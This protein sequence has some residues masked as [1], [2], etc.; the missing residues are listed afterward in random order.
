MLEVLKR[1]SSSFEKES[2]NEE[3]VIFTL[4]S[5]PGFRLPLV[6]PIAAAVVHGRVEQALLGEFSNVLVVLADIIRI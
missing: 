6:A 5:V 1:W 2:V 4:K 3:K